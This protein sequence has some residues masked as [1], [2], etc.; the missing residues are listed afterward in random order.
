MTLSTL[1][2]TINHG[3]KDNI[4]STTEIP[5]FKILSTKM[6]N[7]K[8]LQLDRLVQLLTL[9]QNAIGFEYDNQDY[10]NAILTFDEIIKLEKYSLYAWQNKIRI[11]AETE[12]I[13]ELN[14]TTE[15][16]F[17]IYEE[18]RKSKSCNPNYLGE[19]IDVLSYYTSE[20]INIAKMYEKLNI[21]GKALQYYEKTLDS[22][23]FN[24]DVLLYFAQFYEDKTNYAV[25][26]HFY[27]QVLQHMNDD[28]LKEDIKQK[29]DKL[30]GVQ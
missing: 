2:E 23:R 13:E 9:K 22:D 1:L 29:I 19:C 12:Q 28:K 25:A 27:D 30:K 16:Y 18:L 3:S 20:L 6:P 21:Q 10:S 26:I 11:L 8:F 5:H 7:D 17:I 24:I 14:E 15:K 4:L